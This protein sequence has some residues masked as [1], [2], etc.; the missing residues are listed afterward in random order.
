MPDPKDKTPELIIDSDW[1]S[2]AQAEKDRL[3][4]EEAKAGPDKAKG[5]RAP[6]PGELPPAD[7][8]TLVGMLATQAIMYLGGIADRK[9]GHA[10]FD[11]DYA[12]HMI[13]LLGVLQEKTKGNLSEDEEQDLTQLVHELRARFVELAT[14]MAQQQASGAANPNA[15]GVIGGIGPGIR[16][17]P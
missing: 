17:G 9:T 6:M 1:K 14:L 10:I 15:P 13:D 8:Q 12:R 4:A 7:F 3:A 16:P 11:P 5:G 2:Q